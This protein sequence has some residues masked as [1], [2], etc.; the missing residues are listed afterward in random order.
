MGSL[1]VEF[2]LRGEWNM[3]SQ[4]DERRRAA[5]AT[6]KGDEG[7]LSALPG[8]KLGGWA[9]REA[10][11][12][13]PTRPRPGAGKGRAFHVEHV[14]KPNPVGAIAGGGGVRP[15]LR[16]QRSAPLSRARVAIRIRRIAGAGQ[17]ASFR[18]G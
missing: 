12:G 5:A 4:G 7:L 9:A 6:N 11:A 10:G 2:R 3:P 14:L 16:A 17:G 8:R 13:F 18:R 15:A 1:L